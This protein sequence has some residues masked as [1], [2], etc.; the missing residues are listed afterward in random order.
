[1]FDKEKNFKERLKFLNNC[2]K[3]SN[4]TP[5]AFL[6]NTKNLKSEI[7]NIIK[8][9]YRFVKIH[10][11]KL[12]INYQNIKFYK[13]VFLKLK[14]KTNIIIL[15][16]TFD[17]WTNQANEL[18]QIEVLSKLINLAPKNKIIL[19]H[20]GGPNLLKFYEKFRFLNNVYIDLSYTLLH[21]QKTSLE[22]DIIFLMRNF[23]KRLTIGS[24]F[25]EFKL[26]DLVKISK[27]YSIKS[28]ISEI[29]R[30]NIFSNNLKK[31]IHEKL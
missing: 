1:M 24:D 20:G 29:K 25:P 31:L 11:R 16:C 23:D 30:K 19:M 22:K 2:K 28:K 27:K 7:D 6:R 4:L 10:P 26:N 18:N 17:G 15:W 9:K 12:K 14:K 21:Y 8:L 13:K 5:V 3:F